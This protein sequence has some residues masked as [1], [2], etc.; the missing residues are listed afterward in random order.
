MLK[1]RE[2]RCDIDQDNQNRRQEEEAVRKYRRQ[3]CKQ[4]NQN[5]DLAGRLDGVIAQCNKRQI[6]SKHERR[7]C[8][9][10]CRLGNRIKDCGAEDT[11]VSS[12]VSELP[13]DN[14]AEYV[15][16]THRF[17]QNKQ[18]EVNNVLDN[19]VGITEDPDEGIQ[20]DA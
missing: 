11:E 18:Y 12:E 7:K 2:G 19:V 16:V 15:F 9:V 6:P 13:L 8:I 3:P 17:N 20:F 5:M 14:A 10:D 1:Q 4:G